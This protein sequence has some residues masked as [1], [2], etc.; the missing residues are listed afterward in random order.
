MARRTHYEYEVT[1]E[2]I[3]ILNY[4]FHSPQCSNTATTT[5]TTSITTPSLPPPNKQT[6]NYTTKQPNN[7]VPQYSPP[8]GPLADFSA[9]PGQPINAQ[10]PTHSPI[11]GEYALSACLVTFHWFP[12]C[13]ITGMVPRMVKDDVWVMKGM[14]M[15]GW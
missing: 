11:R 8:I 3:P 7:T 13:H 15:R 5:T 6:N 14:V 2:L 4:F 1:K 10:H 12:R 9:T